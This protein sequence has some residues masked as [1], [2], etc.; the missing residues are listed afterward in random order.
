MVAF[1][2]GLT[3]Q[4]WAKLDMES[5]MIDVQF[6]PTKK[7]RDIQAHQ[8]W[9]ILV[10]W[11][12]LGCSGKMGEQKKGSRLIT[13]GELAVLMGYTAQSGVTLS[14]AL[15][16]IRNFCRQNNLPELNLIVV[17]FETGEPGDEASDADGKSIVAE[18]KKV[19]ETNWFG[20]RQPPIRAF[21]EALS[22]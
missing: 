10:G 11:V 5:T 21:R 18:Q 22:D 9:L 3:A 8:I 15:A 20:I 19:L 7:T 4:T 6:Y 1:L 16:K 12:V 14:K 13:Y 17:N 2:P